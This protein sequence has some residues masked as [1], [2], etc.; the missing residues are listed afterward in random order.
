MPTTGNILKLCYE[1]IIFEL[2]ENIKIGWKICWKSVTSMMVTDVGDQKCWW[3]V[4]DG[5][6]KSRHQ[7]QELG[8]NIKY[9]SP[10]SHS[11][12]L[13][14]ELPILVPQEL[15]IDSKES[16]LNLAPSHSGM[17]VAE[18]NGTNM[19]K[20]TTNILFCRLHLRMTTLNRSYPNLN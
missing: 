19:Q 17:L 6:E 7:Y 11:G 3:Q 20:N 18:W 14:C 13:W 15:L 10:T 1:K 12:V 5:G 4:W 16:F 8:T 9:Q 2:Y